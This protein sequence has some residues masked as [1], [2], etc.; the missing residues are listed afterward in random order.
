MAAQLLP[1]LA[2]FVCGHVVGQKRPSLPG[3]TGRNHS[4]LCLLGIGSFTQ[5]WPSWP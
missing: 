1:G 3:S 2:W 4:L 5:P